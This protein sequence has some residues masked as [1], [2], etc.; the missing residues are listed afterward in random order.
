MTIIVYEVSQNRGTPSS[1]PFIDWFFHETNQPASLGIPHD[2]GHPHDM[3][4]ICIPP[5]TQPVNSRRFF[6]KT[7][8]V[9]PAVPTLRFQGD[10]TFA[11]VEA[12]QITS[13]PGEK[14]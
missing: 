1:H 6:G 11:A 5:S 9:L 2:Y 4:L 12:Q 7:R 13:Q 3:D 14:S 8:L 10:A